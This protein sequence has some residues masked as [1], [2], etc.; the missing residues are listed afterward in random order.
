MVIKEYGNPQ[1]KILLLLHPMLA[2][3][4]TMTTLIGNSLQK[5]RVISPDLS[6]QGE[7]KG[8]FISAEK[9][10]KA[11]LAYLK[12]QNIFQIELLFGASLGAR[13]GLELFSE[14][15]IEIEHIVF[16]GAPFFKNAPILKKVVA[17]VFLKKQKRVRKYPER[18]V[19]KMQETYGIFGESMAKSLAGMSKKSI[20]NVVAA[21]C[22]FEFPP[23]DEKLQ[24]KVLLAFGSKDADYKQRK[25]IKKNYPKIRFWV[26]EGYGHCEY[27]AKFPEKYFSELNLL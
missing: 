26:H 14:K 27:L 17:S 20:K 18:S 7:D 16:E 5:Y 22:S 24:E 25:K 11:L 6:G 23:Y 2:D 13:V 10:A 9:E 3:G 1:G 4:K 12:E 15:S 21:C 8:D 19:R